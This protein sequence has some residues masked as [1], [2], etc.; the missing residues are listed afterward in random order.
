MRRAIL[1]LQVNLA[2]AVEPPQ[3]QAA[4]RRPASDAAGAGGPSA[5]RERHAAPSP[6]L[7]QQMQQMQQQ[8]VAPQRPFHVDLPHSHNPLFALQTQ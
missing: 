4:P 2:L 5:R 6:T 1:L 8:A 7:A 3:S